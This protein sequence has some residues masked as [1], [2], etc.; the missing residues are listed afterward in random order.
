M[1]P[2]VS[3]VSSTPTTTRVVPAVG[4]IPAIDVRTITKDYGDGGVVY[5]AL[6]GID[7][8]VHQGEFLML[9]G[10]SRSGRRTLLSA[11]V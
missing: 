1:S 8:V 9:V 7:L 6:K 4:A 11:G 10:P 2:A 3:S 5:R